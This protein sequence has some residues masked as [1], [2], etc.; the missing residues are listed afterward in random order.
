MPVVMWLI[1][2]PKKALMIAAFLAAIGTGGYLYW[3]GGED[4][5]DKRETQT[6]KETVKQ[7]EK[8][9]EI[10]NNRPDSAELIDILLDGTF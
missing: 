2:N 7:Q 6:L 10:R 9:N 5:D 3:R 1:T 4:R 8:M